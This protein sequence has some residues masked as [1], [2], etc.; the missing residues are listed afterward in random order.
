MRSRL[1]KM[2]RL[3]EHER[4]REMNLMWISTHNSTLEL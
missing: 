4:Q 1:I 2:E 3:L